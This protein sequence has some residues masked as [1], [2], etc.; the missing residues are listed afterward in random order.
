MQFGSIT[1]GM[2][3]LIRSSAL[4]GTIV[5]TIYSLKLVMKT[6]YKHSKNRSNE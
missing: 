4:F 5:A 6:D 2:L 1:R 3:W